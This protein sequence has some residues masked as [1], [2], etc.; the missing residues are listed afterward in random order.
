MFHYFDT[1]T[2][3]RGDSLPN[4]QVECVVLD[5]TTVVPIFADENGTPIETVSGVVNRAV[6]DE[7]GNYDFY[8]PSG[9]YSLRFYSAQG[10]FQRPQRYVPMYGADFA[11]GALGRIISGT[12]GELIASDKNGVIVFTNTAPCTFTITTAGLAFLADYDFTEFH[13]MGTGTV[14]FD[15]GAGVVLTSLDGSRSLAGQ[16]AVAAIRRLS[17]TTAN[18]AGA[19]A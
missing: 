1:V 11:T 3:T 17:S 6:A 2:N 12:T 8:V 14:T 9:T 7:N 4:W 18:L 16:N 19:L 13:R 15:D 5:G 10:V